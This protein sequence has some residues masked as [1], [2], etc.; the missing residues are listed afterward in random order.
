MMSTNLARTRGRLRRFFTS[1]ATYNIVRISLLLIGIYL[2]GALLVWLAE[3]GDKD[4]MI[5]SFPK[6]L[7][8]TLVTLSKEGVIFK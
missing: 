8:Y 5:D 3:S 4:A 2:A 6:A 7:W 1:E